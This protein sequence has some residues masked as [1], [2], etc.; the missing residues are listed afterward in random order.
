MRHWATCWRMFGSAG[1]EGGAGRGIK[2]L[3]GGRQLMTLWI[4]GHLE[5]GWETRVHVSSLL[6][7]AKTDASAAVLPWGPP[8]NHSARFSAHSA[9]RGLVLTVCS[10]LLFVLTDHNNEK[11]HQRVLSCRSPGLKDQSV[12]TILLSYCGF[13][14]KLYLQMFTHGFRIFAIENDPPPPPPPP[15]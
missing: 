14:P 3:S 2:A 13:R 11:L 12:S 5:A 6:S 1:T 4:N 9:V 8:P 7:A 15:K 10:H